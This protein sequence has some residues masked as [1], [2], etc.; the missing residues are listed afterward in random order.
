M[1][2]NVIFGVTWKSLPSGPVSDVDHRV[3]TSRYPRAQL[4]SILLLRSV[5]YLKYRVFFTH[6]SARIVRVFLQLHTLALSTH[7]LITLSFCLRSSTDEVH[8]AYS[9]FCLFSSIRR[10]AQYSS[11]LI[12]FG[13][14]LFGSARLGSARLPVWMTP[15][16][17]GQ[18][19]HDTSCI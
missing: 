9:A 8:L 1:Y 19:L 12:R 13:S 10:T 6:I 17:S 7:A 5:Q 18:S 11:G 4:Q 15:K 14:A 2:A 16:A 3:R